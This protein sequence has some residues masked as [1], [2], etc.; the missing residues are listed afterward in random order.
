[1]SI[2]EEKIRFILNQDPFDAQIAG[3]HYLRSG[4]PIK[5]INLIDNYFGYNIA[6]A[7]KYACRCLYKGQLKEDLLKV[8]HYIALHKALRKQGFVRVRVM[9]KNAYQEIVDNLKILS[10]DDSC[11]KLLLEILD[12]FDNPNI[13]TET[14]I[15]KRISDLSQRRPL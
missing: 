5:V 15:I 2:S 14:K 8:V 4:N 11:K 9:D 6:T 1:M 7:C 13:V 3:N 10:L 12:W